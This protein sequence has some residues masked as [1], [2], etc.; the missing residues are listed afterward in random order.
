MALLLDVRIIKQHCQYVM[1][2]LFLE[3]LHISTPSDQAPSK[4]FQDLL[5]SQAVAV[6]VTNER[7]VISA[8]LSG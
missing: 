1:C 3:E 2:E 4:S 5:C 6:H 8:K 7:Q